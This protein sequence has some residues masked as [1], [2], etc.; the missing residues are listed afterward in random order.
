[1]NQ[2]GNYLTAVVHEGG[3]FSEYWSVSIPFRRTRERSTQPF[4]LPNSTS[5]EKF[6]NNPKS[7]IVLC[8][9]VSS[10]R[11]PE[12]NNQFTRITNYGSV[13]QPKHDLMGRR[14][15][16]SSS[17]T[18]GFPIHCNSLF[19]C[20]RSCCGI[21]ANDSGIEMS[22]WPAIVSTSWPSMSSCTFCM[23]PPKFDWTVF[24]IA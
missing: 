9:L 8:H 18:T 4:H 11:V 20:S 7:H 3:W 13:F 17:A 1:M 19:D 24:R 16:L 21:A 23:S 12:T 14:G 5:L 22:I 10:P 6:V 15:S 2:R